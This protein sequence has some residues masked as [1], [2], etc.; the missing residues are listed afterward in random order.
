MIVRTEK[1]LLLAK[2]KMTNVVISSRTMN[3]W[4]YVFSTDL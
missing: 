1:K 2:F 3:K 4:L